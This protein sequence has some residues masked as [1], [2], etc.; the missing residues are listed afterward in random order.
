VYSGID[1]SELQPIHHS[2]LITQLANQSAVQEAG[3]TDSIRYHC[4]W[5]DTEESHQR[6]QFCINMESQFKEV[7]RCE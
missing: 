5:P 1:Q 2:L 6:E 4:D 7:C 3:A